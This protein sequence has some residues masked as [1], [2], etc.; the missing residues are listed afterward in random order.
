MKRWKKLLSTLLVLCLMLAMLPGTALAETAVPHSAITCAGEILYQDKDGTVKPLP[1]ADIK[2]S[3]DDGTAVYGGAIYNGVLMIDP[4]T[5]SADSTEMEAG[6]YDLY[7]SCAYGGS[8]TYHQI[9]VYGE[10]PITIEKAGDGYCF[11]PVVI[12]EMTVEYYF[13]VSE[14]G[15]RKILTECSY[16]LTQN[17][18]VIS[19]GITSQDPEYQTHLSFPFGDAQLIICKDSYSD[20]IGELEPYLDTSGA[21]YDGEHPV[22]YPTSSAQYRVDFYPNG[23][24]IISIRGFSADQITAGSLTAQENDIFVDEYSGVGMMMTNENGWLDSLPVVEREGYVL[25]GWYIVPASVMTGGSLTDFTGYTKVGG[26]TLYTSDT[27]L[28]AKWTKASSHAGDFRFLSSTYHIQVGEEVL[29]MAYLQNG[30]ELPNGTRINVTYSK[31]DI[32]DCKAISREIVGRDIIDT[33]GDADDGDAYIMVDVKGVASGTV[34]LT[35]ELQDGRSTSCE[36]TVTNTGAVHPRGYDFDTDSY[37][38]ENYTVSTI[39]EKYFTT[40]YEEGPGK[41]LY[42]AKKNMGKV[43]LCF[44]MAY[45]TAAIYNDLPSCSTISNRSIM[46]ILEGGR[47]CNSI[48]EISNFLPFPNDISSF[49]I[50]NNE[51]TIDDYIKYA[52]IYQL[53]SNVTKAAEN[54]LE[55][56]ESLYTAVK[57]STDSNQ[58]KVTIKL[59]HYELDSRGNRIIGSNGDPVATAHRV[60]AV[61]YEGN[62]ILIDDPNNSG[63]LERLIIGADGSWKYS[64]AWAADG[65]NNNNSEICYSLDYYQPYLTLLTGKRVSASD[66]FL[67]GATIQETYIEGMER[68]DANN[69][70]LYL[71]NCDGATLPKNAVKITTDYDTSDEYPGDLYWIENAASVNVSDLVGTDSTVM[72]AGDSTIITATADQ[73]TAFRG[74]IDDTCQNIELSSETENTCTI[75]YETVSSETDVVL[76]ISGVIANGTVSVQTTTGGLKING[77]SSGS[78][79]LRHDDTQVGSVSFS[80]DDHSFELSYDNTGESSTVSVSDAGDRSS[81]FTDVSPDAYYYQAVLWAV[82]NSVTIGTGDGTTFSP[83]LACDRGQIVTFLWRANGCPEPK[84]KNNPFTDVSESAYYY[85]AVLWAVENNITI[86][87]G[88]G[89]T[90]GPGLVCT[91]DQTVTFLWR[92][93]GMPATASAVSFTDVPANAYYAPAVRWAVENNITIGTGDGTTFSPSLNCD[94]SQIVTFLYRTYA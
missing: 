42:A 86:G 67:E 62:D 80:D 65:V 60:L 46:S 69:T 34:T 20:F 94:R 28:V 36:V 25:D 40:I 78:I 76:E 85:K 24:S 66:T 84:S 45:T 31:P 39:S 44:G 13:N 54:T 47:N 41:A 22:L 74:T 49:A 63:N 38:F 68:L 33:T 48:R 7:I 35:L 27:C 83:T 53:S 71:E 59:I 29:L 32:I 3:K 61:G 21:N 50:G 91:R 18:R 88:D 10:T 5:N 23:G 6:S 30:S 70:L 9:Y 16:E 11:D 55:D 19:S 81:P 64:G 15:T 14:Y 17:G 73:I 43:G 26:S 87:T 56:I 72:I 12:S 51:I 89:T 93:V 37:G 82:E 52:H 75:S 57:T 58:I 4:G 77:L 79:V 1:A 90:F 8:S 92:A 2:M